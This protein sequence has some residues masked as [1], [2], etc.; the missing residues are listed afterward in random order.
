M[1]ASAIRT[2]PLFSILDLIALACFVGAWIAYA[3]TVERTL[4]GRRSLRAPNK[5]SV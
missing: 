3:I 2:M 5:T 4:Y 1:R